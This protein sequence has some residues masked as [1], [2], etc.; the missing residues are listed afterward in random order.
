HLRPDVAHQPLKVRAA[1]SLRATE[2]HENI[3]SDPRLVVA[4]DGIPEQL[5]GDEDV[6]IVPIERIEAALDRDD[7]AE[8]HRVVCHRLAVAFWVFDDRT[9]G[10]PIDCAHEGTFLA[11]FGRSHLNYSPRII[12]A[13]LDGDYPRFNGR[14]RQ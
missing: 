14:I 6:R 2:D 1:V 5:A 12:P 10:L 11:S 9:H 4:L 7:A 13:R 8:L 3:G